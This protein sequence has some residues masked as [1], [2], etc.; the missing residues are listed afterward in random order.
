MEELIWA[1]GQDSANELLL[2]QVEV[3][4]SPSSAVNWSANGTINAV[5]IRIWMQAPSIFQ[6]LESTN[7]IPLR[8]ALGAGNDLAMIDTVIDLQSDDLLRA[9]FNVSGQRMDSDTVLLSELKPPLD[10]YE[11]SSHLTLKQDS[12]HLSDLEA[13]LG[14]SQFTGHINVETREE[15]YH[16][17]ARLESPNI[18]TDDFVSLFAQLR[19][20]GQ[21]DAETG[22]ADSDQKKVQEGLAVVLNREIDELTKHYSFEIAATIEKLNSAGNFL[23]KAEIGLVANEKELQLK[24][25]R[26][27]HSGG[28]VEAEYSGKYLDGGGVQTGLSMHIEHLEY[29]GLLRLLDSGSTASGLVYLDASLLATGPDWSHLASA[30]NGTLDLLTIPDDVEAGFLDLWASNVVLAL[31]PVTS[32]SGKGKKMNCMVARFEVADGLMESKKILLDS[33]DVLVHGRGG[34]DLG[35]RKLNLLF[36]PQAKLEKFLSISTPIRVS[37]P[38]DDFNVRVA[39]GGFVMTMFR[40]Y[41]SLIYVPYKWLTG[42]RFPADGLATCYHAMD[43]DPADIRVEESRPSAE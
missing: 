2:T 38:F 37:G 36:A 40:W 1:G 27:I 12:L 20:A 22:P 9:E 11:L 39:G 28:N 42:E 8:L 10:D 23:G 14:S 3:T 13:K 24:P 41:M 16:I 43:W 33:T 32:G 26:I 35:Q 5:P 30:T 25:L 19:S 31:L 34:I 21:Q 7:R 17:D 15:P 6:I 18:E 4:S 29:G